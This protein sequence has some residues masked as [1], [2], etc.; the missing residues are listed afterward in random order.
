MNKVDLSQYNNNHYRPGSVVKRGLWYIV[1]LIFFQSYMFPFSSLKCSLLRMFGAKISSGV[2]IKPCVLI[3]Y[4]WFLKIEKNTWIGEKVW[5]DNLAM[6]TIG[7]NVTIS[8]GAMLLTGNHNYK[9]PAFDLEVYPIIIE[10]GVWIG[11]KSVVCPDVTC[12]SHAVLS[13]GSVAVN[14]LDAYK[15][16]SGNPA[17]EVRERIIE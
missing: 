10:D 4:P 7:T 6:I 15:V 3:K 13:V 14:D 2:V 8:Q 16:Y 9:K 1:S 17:T 12:E 5:I 11:A